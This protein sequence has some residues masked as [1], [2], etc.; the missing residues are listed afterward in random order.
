MTQLTAGEAR[1]R[2]AAAPVARLAT[3][4]PDGGP[5]I[6]PVTFAIED[7]RVFVAVDAKPKSTRDLAR[8]RNIS[9]N[10]RVALLADHYEEDWAALW[11]ARADGEARVV[12]AQAEMAWPITLL[13]R[14]YRQYRAAPPAGPVITVTV[15]RWSGWAA[16]QG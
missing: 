4:T 12:S 11:W 2:F 3:I 13:A 1:A 5:H 15:L 8:L 14:R 7:D 16:R 10:P 6:V 9:A